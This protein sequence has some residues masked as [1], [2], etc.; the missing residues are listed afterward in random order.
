MSRITARIYDAEGNPG[1]VISG[2]LHQVQAN[3]PPGGHYEEVPADELYRIPEDPPT[4]PSE[5]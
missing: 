4:L 2:A 3:V 1:A 5:G